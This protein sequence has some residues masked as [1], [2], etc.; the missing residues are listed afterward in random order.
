MRRRVDALQRGGACSGPRARKS[1]PLEKRRGRGSR[2]RAAHRE[3]RTLCA[4][5]HAEPARAA[6]AY[7]LR[8]RI[9]DRIRR[10]LRP[11]F[12]RPFPVFFVPTR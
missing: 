2:A 8:C 9:L 12:S 5:G 1:A 11:S 4:T 6:G 10:F 3:A 7:Y